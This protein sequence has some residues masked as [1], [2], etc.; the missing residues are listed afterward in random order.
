MS[1]A[2]AD[3]AAQ[4]VVGDVAPLL[5]SFSGLALMSDS[6]RGHTRVLGAVA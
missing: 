6:L 2:L 4:L 1:L 5:M 3:V